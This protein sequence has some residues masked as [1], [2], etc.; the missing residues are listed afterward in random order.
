MQD[1]IRLRLIIENAR[2]AFR[3]TMFTLDKDYW[4]DDPLDRDYVGKWWRSFRQIVLE[5]N[6]IPDDAEPFSVYE[7]CRGSHLAELEEAVASVHAEEQEIANEIAS[8][9]QPYREQAAAEKSALVSMTSTL[10]CYVGIR[11]Y[12]A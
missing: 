1:A 11:P 6:K 9:S 4:T 7:L 5:K 8:I 2:L 10:V 3:R 12:P